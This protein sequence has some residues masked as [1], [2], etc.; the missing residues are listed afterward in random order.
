MNPPPAPFIHFATPLSDVHTVATIPLWIQFSDQRNPSAS[1]SIVSVDPSVSQPP[2]ETPNPAGTGAPV[3]PLVGL[4]ASAHSVRRAA[5]HEPAEAVAPG[6]AAAAVAGPPSPGAAAGPNSVEPADAMHYHGDPCT[7]SICIVD[8]QHG[9]HVLRLPCNHVFHVACWDEYMSHNTGQD[10]TH[11]CPCCRGPG[12]V[13][14]TWNFLSRPA[15]AEPSDPSPGPQPVL[16]NETD[17]DLVDDDVEMPSAPPLAEAPDAGTPPMLEEFVI[18]TP[19]SNAT[20][21]SSVPFASPNSWFGPWWPGTRSEQVFQS[22]V[23]LPDGRLG[24]LIDTGAWGNLQGEVWCKKAAEQARRAGHQPSEKKLDGPLTVN[25]VGSGSQQASWQA[26]IPTALTR[27]DGS[28]GMTQY[29][30]PIVE[31]A[32][33]PPLLGLRSLKANRVILDLVKNEMIVCGPGDCK[34]EPPPGSETYPLEH[35]PSGHLVLP[36]S[37]YRK[38]Q[39]QKDPQN[40]I[41]AL[42]SQPVETSPGSPAPTV[43]DPSSPDSRS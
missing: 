41:N 17:S 3:D 35:T 28:V 23:E 25:G 13:I 8:F 7:C 43:L 21:G 20:S 37:A 24:L 27:T 6:A 33:L 26:T 12:T 38:Y 39:S 42:L 34:I 40:T 19:R 5:E 1:Q 10:A 30:A 18:G 22:S 31:G 36:I 9:E 11:T 29:T 14:A 32:D 15:G 4:F 16:N 2:V